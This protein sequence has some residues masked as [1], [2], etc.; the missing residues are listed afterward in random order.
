MRTWS[1]ILWTGLILPGLVGCGGR[2]K[3]M[4]QH[5]FFIETLDRRW[6]VVR[7]KFQ[8]ENPD[9]GFVVILLKDLSNYPRHKHILLLLKIIYILIF[10]FF[11][12]LF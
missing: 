10:S 4:S 2:A 3:K 5:P 7:E 12:F 11:Y 8:S 1:A 9:V 6:N